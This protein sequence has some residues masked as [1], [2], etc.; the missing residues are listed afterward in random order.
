MS[1][2][3]SARLNDDLY[4]NIMLFEGKNFTEKLENA[5]SDIDNVVSDKQSVIEVSDIEEKVSDTVNYT[6][7]GEQSKFLVAFIQLYRCNFCKWWTKNEDI[8]NKVNS[9][10]RGILAELGYNNFNESEFSSFSDIDS[11]IKSEFTWY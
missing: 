6:L 10:L 11:L 3:I 1:V 9:F 8:D 2:K 5:L 7:N 4:N